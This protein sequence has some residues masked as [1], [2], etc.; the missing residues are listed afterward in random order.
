[1]RRIF[2]CLQGAQRGA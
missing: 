1:L 2:V